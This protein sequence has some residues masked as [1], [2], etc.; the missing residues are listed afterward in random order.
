MENLLGKNP[1]ENQIT[2]FSNDL[3]VMKDCPPM[4][5]VHAADDA[6]VPVENS[7]RFYLACVHNKVPA[8]MHLYPKGGHGFGLENKTT[9]EN[10][11]ERL[12]NH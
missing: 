4:F 6:T 10:W 3:Q 7:V 9:R 5:L 1:V 8:E 11:M 12:A 2:F